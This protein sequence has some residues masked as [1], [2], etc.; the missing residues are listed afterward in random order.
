MVAPSVRWL[1]L[2]VTLTAL[3]TQTDNLSRFGSPSSDGGEVGVLQD[4][5]L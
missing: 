3:E 2:C 4:Y 1:L 5:R